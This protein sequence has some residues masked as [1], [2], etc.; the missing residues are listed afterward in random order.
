MSFV[1]PGYLWFLGLLTLPILI[2]LFYFRRHKRFYFPSLKYLKQQDQEKKTVK[3]LKRWV[4]LACRLL[5]AAAFILAFA[6]PQW[7]DAKKTKDGIPITVIY[8]DNSYSMTAKGVEG[9]LLSESKETAKRMINEGN[10]KTRYML[11]SNALSGIE[12]KVHN[13]LTAIQYVDELSLSRIPRNIASVMTF[14]DEYLRRYNQEI[15][16]I[17]SI[18]RILLSDFQKYNS[19]LDNYVAQNLEIPCKTH[20]VQTVPQRVENRTI[21]SLWTE[22]PVHKPGQALT[23]FC[24]VNNHSDAPVENLDVTLL[25]DG[26]KRMTTLSVNAHQSGIANFTINPQRTGYLEGKLSV[27]DPTVTWDDEF[28]FTNRS[29]EVAKILIVNGNGATNSPEK[30]FQTEPFYEVSSKGEQSFGLS[31]LRRVDLLVLNGLNTLPSGMSEL[32]KNYVNQGGSVF[33]LPG[34]AIDQKEYNVLLNALGLA[35]FSGTTDQGNQVASIQYRSTFFRGMFEKE[36]KDLNLPL[37]KT[38]NVQ[39]GFR[40]S[41]SE[42]LIQLR[43]NFPLLLHQR[44]N[45]NVFLL[46]ACP[47]LFNGGIARHAIYPSMLLR[48]AELSIRSL[49]MYYTLGNAAQISLEHNGNADETINLLKDQEEH[50]PKQRQMDN[51]VLI[52]LNTPELME[53][54]SEGIYTLKGAQESL[55][56]GIN[57]DRT[58]SLLSYMDE[59]SLK[60]TFASKGIEQVDFK[61]L[62]RG[63]STLDLS[64]NDSSSY[65]EIFVILALIFALIEM[66]IIKFWNP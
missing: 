56:I 30:V 10:S 36:K 31:D 18:Q 58:E 29:A 5:L 19:S 15:A 59:S 44:T 12:R 61:K 4:V 17:A 33:I 57:S 47:D 66:A 63:A 1:H 43:N 60:N 46:T 9:I 24:R 8:I 20:I 26:K 13:K 54:L 40:Q 49:S 27:T 3:N 7:T 65:W 32:I 41:N 52:Q 34:L 53:H 48:A 55:K 21:D 16:K 42:I 14:Q 22:T 23:L 39:R 2:H 6:Q 64:L 38:L 11:C 37:I 35:T 25:F 50:I 28:F 45:G 62:D 51:R